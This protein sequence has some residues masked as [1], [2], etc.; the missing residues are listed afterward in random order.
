MKEIFNVSVIIPTLNEEMHIEKCLNSV[1]NQTCF[2]NI[3]EILVVDGGSTDMTL[4]IVKMYC[5]TQ[6][7]M[8]IMNNIKKIQSA[9][10]NIGIENFKGD[11]LVRLD[12]HCTFDPEYIHYC[13]QYHLS[14][15]YGNV[16]GRCH[17]EPGSD[18]NMA[19]VIA[20]ASTSKFGLGFA[21]FR[22]GKKKTLTD[23]VPFGS[24]SRKVL[25]IVGKM[26][27]S[28]PR[29]EDNEYNAR[30]RVNGYRVLFDPKIIS[31]YYSVPKLKS[32]LNKMFTNGFSIGVLLR[33][34]RQSV[35]FR[36]LV[37]LI[38]VIIL[39]LSTFL[40]LFSHSMKIALLLFLFVYLALLLLSAIK[41]FTKHKI[42]LIPMYVYVI[43]IVHIYYGAGTI[44]GLIQGKYR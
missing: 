25:S 18:T 6:P 36:H 24:F 21:A 29:G 38:F 33:I 14:A 23:S 15:E 22:V 17:I 41:K 39:A 40:S 10:F 12:A 31:Y 9:A 4:E 28:L 20:F 44:L 1:F 32:F 16:G 19:K 7:K 13:I 3:V 27:E 26:N 5:L 37:P 11:F 42:Y 30:I 8:L 43:F 34:S 35:S 2:E